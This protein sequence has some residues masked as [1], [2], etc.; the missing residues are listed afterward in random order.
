MAAL[1]LGVPGP[2]SCHAVMLVDLLAWPI[3]NAVVINVNATFSET[4]PCLL[5][6]YSGNI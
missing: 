6:F 4:V 1:H 2:V 5:D 3:G